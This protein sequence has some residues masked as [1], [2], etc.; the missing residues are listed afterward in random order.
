MLKKKTPLNISVTDEKKTS[1][2]GVVP[3]FV[4]EAFEAKPLLTVE[5]GGGRATAI[6]L[7]CCMM[8]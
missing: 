6:A 8:S 3:L 4:Q 7:L 1:S 2:V 5:R